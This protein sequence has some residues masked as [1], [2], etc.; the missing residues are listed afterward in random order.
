[1]SA[2]FILLHAINAPLW[3]AMLQIVAVFIDKFRRRSQIQNYIL[4]LHNLSDFPSAIQTSLNIIHFLCN[5]S[6]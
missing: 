4:L 1:M 5:L 6:E 3:C 2:F